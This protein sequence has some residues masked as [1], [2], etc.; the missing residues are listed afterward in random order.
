MK[1]DDCCLQLYIVRHAESVSNANEGLPQ[2]N[3]DKL[4]PV[5]SQLGHRQ[6]EAV[7]KRFSGAEFD[8]LI[9]SPYTRAVQ[10]AR[11]IAEFHPAVPF[12]TDGGLCE[13]GTAVN[14][15]GTFIKIA[16]SDE[17]CQARATDFIKKLRSVYHSGESVVLV[18]HAVFTEFLIHAAFDIKRRQGKTLCIYNSSVSK[19]KF[20]Y[21][22]QIKIAFIN[23]TGH[24]PAV[25]EDRIFWI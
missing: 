20:Y 10:T 9:T 2:N 1:N 11:E 15:D 25:E 17:Q 23:D 7:G 21:D 5:L 22:G 24:I 19:L 4:D 6:A 16:E 3:E 14:P 13:F 18:T 12:K 8:A